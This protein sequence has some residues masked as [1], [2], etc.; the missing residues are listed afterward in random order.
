MWPR[1]KMEDKNQDRTR[2]NGQRPPYRPSMF[3]NVF[4]GFYDKFQNVPLRAFD[5]FIGLCIAAIVLLIVVGT[6]QGRGI[7]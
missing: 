6:L 7:I 1:S 5:L 3:A 4:R 2:E